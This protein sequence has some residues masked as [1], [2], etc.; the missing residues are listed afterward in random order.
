MREVEVGLVELT[1]VQLICCRPRERLDFTG[2]FEDLLVIDMWP[3]TGIV[4]MSYRKN[5][6]R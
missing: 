2:D 3:Q 1:R 6:R 5:T 4:R